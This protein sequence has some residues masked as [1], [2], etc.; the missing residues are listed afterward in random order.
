M[1]GS[2]WKCNLCEHEVEGTSPFYP[3]ASF[4][5]SDNLFAVSTGYFSN[6]DTNQLRLDQLQRPELTKG[7]IDFTVSSA[8]EYHTPPAAPRLVLTYYTPEPP[9]S[10]SPRR[11]P[12]L[13]RI[14][15]AIDVSREATE[16]GL[17]AVAWETIIGVLYG[18]EASVGREW[19]H[20]SM[21][22]IELKLWPMVTPST[23]MIYP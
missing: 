10:P 18:Y 14:L 12:E 9:P 13:L 20:V 11:P 23:S 4:L 2:R 3:E 16:C 17:T 5:S 21:R 15:Y 1:F 8:K 6:L 22:T 7:T 19:S